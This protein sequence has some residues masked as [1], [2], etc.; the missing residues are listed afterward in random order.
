MCLEAPS[1]TLALGLPVLCW[2]S[3]GEGIDTVCQ[4]RVGQAFFPPRLLGET[5]LLLLAVLFMPVVLEKGGPFVLRLCEEV[6]S[7]QDWHLFPS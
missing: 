2:G 5:F 6:L 7:S 3:E 4:G 1:W